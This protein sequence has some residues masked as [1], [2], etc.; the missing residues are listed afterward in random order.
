MIYENVVAPKITIGVVWKLAYRPSDPD[1]SPRYVHGAEL[2]GNRMS[3]T[4]NS[5][6][7]YQEP[8][9]LKAQHSSCNVL[10]SLL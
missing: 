8:G 6:S 7:L 2:M 3:L 9:F 1:S 10:I 4:A 5:A